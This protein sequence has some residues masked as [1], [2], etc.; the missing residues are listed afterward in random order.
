LL[1]PGDA[2]AGVGVPGPITTKKGLTME[3]RR[4]ATPVY[5]YYTLFQGHELAAMHDIEVEEFRDRDHRAV[6]A[7]YWYFQ[8][9]N[10]EP[11]QR[12]F[13][14]SEGYKTKEEAIHAAEKA[15]GT[16]EWGRQT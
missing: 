10:W 13:T 1:A 9:Y 12:D 14:Y 6:V 4:I 7:E 16:C 11:Y 8:P 5:H 15:S 3:E 2:G